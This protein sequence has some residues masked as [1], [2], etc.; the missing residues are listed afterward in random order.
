M[1]ATKS[2]KHVFW[3]LSV[4]VFQDQMAL[5]YSKEAILADV[6]ILTIF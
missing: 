5:T 3:I 4:Y 6:D 1:A 2:P